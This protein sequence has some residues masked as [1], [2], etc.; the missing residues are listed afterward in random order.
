MHTISMALLKPVII[1]SLN[2]ILSSFLS[3]EILYNY[4]STFVF[5]GIWLYSQMEATLSNGVR[6]PSESIL[7][8]K[9]LLPFESTPLFQKVP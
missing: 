6:L 3:P 5:K 7:I 8:I 4:P 2:E 9:N 1:S